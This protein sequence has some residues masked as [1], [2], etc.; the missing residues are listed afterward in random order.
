MKIYYVLVIYGFFLDNSLLCS[1]AKLQQNMRPLLNNF[2]KM[3][4]AAW[5][6]YETKNKMI[7]QSE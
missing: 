2:K 5:N 6:A 1:K 3:F 4:S 7:K